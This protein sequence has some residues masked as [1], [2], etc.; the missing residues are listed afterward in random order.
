VE[1][2]QTGVGPQLT[3]GLVTMADAMQVVN[4][5]VYLLMVILLLAI[6]GAFV[7]LAVIGHA[8]NIV[9][10]LAVSLQDAVLPVT[11][12]TAGMWIAYSVG[13][14]LYDAAVVATALL[15]MAG[16][17]VAIDSFGPIADNAGGIAEMAELSGDMRHM[18][19]A[20]DAVSNA[21]KAVVVIRNAGRYRGGRGRAFAQSSARAPHHPRSCRAQHS[22]VSL[23]WTGLPAAD[24][25]VGTCGCSPPAPVLS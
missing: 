4:G 21:T 11:V 6:I 8:T 1:I 13:D 15:T 7:A 22:P 9:T 3:D 16:I 17:V 20:L 23:F 10:G 19:N 18:S 25:R 24:R 12:I 2:G 14:G 5:L